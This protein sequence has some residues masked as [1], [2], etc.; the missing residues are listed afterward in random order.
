[1][2]GKRKQ[3]D[4]SDDVLPASKLRWPEEAQ[5]SRARKPV[6]P[7]EESTDIWP[8]AA[9]VSHWATSLPTRILCLGMLHDS[10]EC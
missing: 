7:P 8:W 10:Q 3:P 1:M 9:A 4:K 6:Y 5:S 2:S